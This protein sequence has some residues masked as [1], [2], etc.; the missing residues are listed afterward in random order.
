MDGGPLMLI[1]SLRGRLFVGLTLFIVGTGLA[2]GYLAYRW[3]F[4]E[5]IELQDAILLQV[6]SFA[7]KDRLTDL[8]SEGNI[9]GEARVVIEELTPRPGD[10]LPAGSLRRLPQDL[11]DGLQTITHGGERWRILVRTRKDASR[12]AV[13][14]STAHRDEIARESALRTIVPLGLLVPGLMLLIGIV[15]DRSLRPL[16]K[17]ATH[18]DAR[19]SDHLEKLPTDGV[20]Q[21]LLP[22][23]ASINRLLDRIGTMFDKQR[24]FVADA[25]H[26]LRSPITALSV[27]AENLEHAG[28]SHDGRVRLDSLRTG[29]RRTAHLLEQLLALARYDSD[30][31]REMPLSAF[32]R[33]VKEVVADLLPAAQ[34]RSIDLG[35]ARIETASV[36]GEPVALA[37][38]VRNL[39][40]NALRH[41]P[42]G[43]RVDL[44]L[45]RQSDAVIL[46]VADTG[47]GILASEIDRIFE[48]FFRGSRSRGEGT[49]LGLSIVRRIAER[50][51]GSIRLE[52]ARQ[53]GGQGLIASVSFPAV[54]EI[55]S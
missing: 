12:V 13:G 38:L 36:R 28:L 52:N 1:S 19:Q 39:I 3:A 29:I 26:E 54:P 50:C 33:I 47:P 43:G 41:T 15:V 10:R 25:A 35:F 37:I 5:A 16:S 34:D 51:H 32:D 14:Q 7:S 24:R 4:E 21:E 53:P 22:F 17:L 42:A 6:G 18:L 9:D 55:T 31:S 49:G 45:F 20:P 8:P 40:D 30:A 48:P 2:A 23:V 44:S 46:Q 11:R 27:Q